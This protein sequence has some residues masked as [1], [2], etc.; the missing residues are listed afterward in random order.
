MDPPKSNQIH[1]WHVRLALPADWA[2]CLLSHLTP[3]EEARAARFLQP[4]DHERFVVGRAAL[5]HILALYLDLEPG[6]VPIVPTAQ[7]KPRLAPGVVD[8]DLRFNLSHSGTRI[9]IG[10]TDGLDVGVD[11]EWM[12]AELE[13]EPLAR[14]FFSPAEAAEVLGLSDELRR[15]AFYRCWTRKEA[16]LKATGEGLAVGLDRFEVSLLPG[17]PAALRVHLDDPE[18]VQRWRIYEPSLP[19]GYHGAVA[20]EGESHRLVELDWPAVNP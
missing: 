5:R 14:R 20:V 9:L 16:Y 12:R 13:I 15:A 7:G 8:R 19:S 1:V 18:A 17:E 6:N 4:A 10:V 3:D 2:P 11:I